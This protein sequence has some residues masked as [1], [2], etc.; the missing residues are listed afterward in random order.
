VE[1]L[2]MTGEGNFTNIHKFPRIPDRR[3]GH[4]RL[5]VVRSEN[6]TIIYILGKGILYM[7][8]LHFGI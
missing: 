3:S 6:Q 2:L 4:V 5:L 1:L 7:G 8:R